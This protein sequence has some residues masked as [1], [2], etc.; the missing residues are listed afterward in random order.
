MYRKGVQKVSAIANSAD[1][2]TIP[3]AMLPF[4]LDGAQLG[5]VEKVQIRRDAPKRVSGVGL[6]VKLA[7]SSS[8]DLPSPCLLTVR[9]DVDQH[10]PQFHCATAVD[11][12]ADSLTVFGDVR[13]Q[14]G[15]EIRSFYLPARVI[16]DW[17][18]G[19]RNLAHFDADSIAEAS[20]TVIRI[21]AD[22]G[23][24]ALELEARPD[25]ARLRIGGDSAR[26][27]LRATA[28]GAHLMVRSDTGRRK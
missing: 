4:R 11:S 1:P 13:F 18:S 3:L 20:R 19:R 9:D 24:T 25:G 27:E 17:R 5:Q 8:G 10:G 14:P 16:E 22:S 6:V 2:I 28:A 23:D 21:D 7:G 26:V 15:E 12:L